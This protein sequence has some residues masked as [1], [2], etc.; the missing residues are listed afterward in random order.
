[1]FATRPNERAADGAGRNS[2]F[3]QAFLEHIATP[4]KDIELVMRDVA[5]SVRAKTNGRQIPQRLTELE[6]GLML[7]PAR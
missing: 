4:A 2:P 5:A 1:V 3:T 6:H 7:L